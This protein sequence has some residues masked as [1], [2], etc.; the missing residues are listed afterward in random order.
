M[1]GMHIGIVCGS[2]AH[3]RLC[4]PTINW[5]DLLFVPKG[6]NKINNSPPSARLLT[7]HLSSQMVFKL[8][9]PTYIECFIKNYLDIGTQCKILLPC[10]LRL[11]SHA[12]IVS[13]KKI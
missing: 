3:E 12:T 6:N 5:Y 13:L 9:L 11:L 4:R 8:I 7:T 10:T 1:L 2:T